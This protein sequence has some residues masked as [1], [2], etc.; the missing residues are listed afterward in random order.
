MSSSAASKASAD[1]RH[2][3]TSA[4]ARSPNYQSASTD[5]YGGILDLQG[6]AGNQTVNHL[7]QSEKDGS[8][9]TANGV[10]PIVEKVVKSGVG[11]PLDPATRTFM[12]SRFGQDFSDMRVHTDA[13]AAESAQAVNALAYTAGT[14][15]VFG[16]DRY[17]AQ[18]QGGKHL[19]GHEL[20]HVVQQSGSKNTSHPQLSLDHPGSHREH[21]AQQLAYGID[22]PDN[23]G[24]LPPTEGT[25]PASSDIARAPAGIIQ[26]QLITPLGQGGGVGDLTERDRREPS[27]NVTDVDIPSAIQL[28][29]RAIAELDA[30]TLKHANVAQ[31]V[32][33]I[34]QLA[35]AYWAGNREEESIIQIIDTTPHDQAA[36]L[37]NQLADQKLNDRSLLDE[38][39]RVVDIGNNLDLHAALSKLRLKA[40][41]VEGAHEATEKAPILPWSESGAVFSVTR[42]RTG[43]VRVKYP[44]I[45]RLK[46][47]FE[48]VR[49]LPLDLF[50]PPGH[51][52]DPEQVLL[53]R[54]YDRINDDKDVA[55]GKKSDLVP[56]VA[57]ELSG[58]RHAAKRIFLTDVAEIASI[59]MPGGAAKSIIGKAALVIVERIIPITSLLLRKNRSQFLKWFPNWGPRI[60]GII[61]A[62]ELTIGLFGI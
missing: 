13:K 57:R 35:A 17:Q 8:R 61:Q 42:T 60:I 5:S 18:T 31:R 25:R 47:Q 34:K 50:L 37:L 39:D 19:L 59:A 48:E 53:I 46:E 4:A 1:K 52:F 22:G 54:D 56:I 2:K 44:A 58:Y 38:V 10:P 23:S 43:K 30:E 7:L 24:F 40:L 49:H 45:V 28:G 32:E 41:G 14:N 20:A 55:E 16:K 15:I 51:E 3:K 11:Q 26:R 21:A 33:M 62:A 6:L 36:E 12:E 29:W 9:T 27:V